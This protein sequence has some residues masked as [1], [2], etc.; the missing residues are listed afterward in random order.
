MMSITE[1]SLSDPVKD[2]WAIREK[3]HEDTKNMT[4]EEKKEY[5]HRNVKNFNRL[6][7]S[8]NPENDDFPFL[9]KK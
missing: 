1:I 9:A 3:I 6:M 5:L 2:V 8:I 7:E 4:R